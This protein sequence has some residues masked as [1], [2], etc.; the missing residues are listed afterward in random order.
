[1]E[2]EAEKPNEKDLTL[3]ECF[4]QVL[5]RHLERLIGTPFGIGGLPL[6]LVNVASLILLTEQITQ[7]TDNYSTPAD[8]YT[9]STL[10]EELSEMGL[11]SDMDTSGLL[12]EIIKKGY[13]ELDQG[14]ELSPNKPAISMAQLLDRVFPRMP[15]INLIATLAQ[16]LD[17]AHS[18]SHDLESAVNRFDQILK[19]QGVS[20]KAEEPFPKIEGEEKTTPPSITPY[21]RTAQPK[22][23]RL[24]D[25]YDLQP[26]RDFQPSSW[27]LPRDSGSTPVQR[28][29]G[30][31]DKIAAVLPSF[32]QEGPDHATP[33]DAEQPLNGQG[34]ESL[35]VADGKRQ[36]EDGAPP[37]VFDARDEAS[38]PIHHDSSFEGMLSRQTAPLSQIDGLENAAAC[39]ERSIEATSVNTEV[40]SFSSDP[41]EQGLSSEAFGIETRPERPET[42]T[43]RQDVP[44]EPE[45]A[46]EDEDI[47]NRIAE[48][49][50]KLS[51]Q[52]PICETG[53]LTEN[54]TSTGKRFFKC[55]AVSCPFI[56]WG[57]PFHITCPQCKN[58]FLIEVTGREGIAMLK[59][60]RATCAHWQKHPFETEKAVD[61]TPSPSPKKLVRVRKGSGREK[62]KVVR[63]RVVRKRK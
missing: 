2:I 57:K 60:P 15:G 31:E 4:D 7:E 20:L 33:P 39:Q 53:V 16:T 58:P 32:P 59:C 11:A 13:I 8:R 24:S 56:S 46:P 23:M 63:R 29:D 5:L 17:E 41:S 40:R 51:L 10:F 34:P 52:C 50:G 62:R 45:I 28:H 6:N 43:E 12:D 35:G 3:R 54:T 49:E 26:D 37:P 27:P 9:R 30:S 38:F 61:R 18:G 1:M 42:F 36:G 48:F 55:T 22:R 14:G 21:D 44:F 19:M 25:I 47:E